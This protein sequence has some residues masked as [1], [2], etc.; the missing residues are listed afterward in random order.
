MALPFMSRSSPDTCSYAVLGKLPNRPDFVRYNAVHPVIREFDGVVQTAL[1]QLSVDLGW[2]ALY[3]RAPRTDFYYTSADGRWVFYGGWQ[4]SRDQSGRRYPFWAGLIRPVEELSWDAPLVPIS[5]EVYFDSLHS[6]ISNA[7]EN[8]VEAVACREFLQSQGGMESRGGADRDLARGLVGQF[9]SDH[10]VADLELFL[11]SVGIPS[12]HQALLNIAF[13]LAFL[14]NYDNP[15]LIQEIALPLP[16]GKGEGALFA[17]TWLTILSALW[18]KTPWRGSYFI[19]TGTDTP[20]L[21]VSFSRMP[22]KLG[23]VFEGL[24]G[25]GKES[26]LDLATENGLWRTHAEYAQTAFALSRVVS[27]P[28]QPLS[29]VVGVVE[30][31]GEKLSA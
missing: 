26:A 4:V 3:D 18:G 19:H 22:R 11:S 16:K 21:S 9:L 17:S 8:S 31:I 29:V 15:A 5:H 20:G 6:Q 12:L 14:R 23:Y 28:Q 10:T 2:E 25:Q 30:E 13:Y 24:G 27:D 1:E 7:I